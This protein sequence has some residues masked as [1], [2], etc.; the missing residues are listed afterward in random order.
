LLVCLLALAG[1]GGGDKPSS[2]P[3]R[4]AGGGVGTKDPVPNEQVEDAINRIKGAAT[5]SGCEAVKGL[6]H[7]TYGDVSDD[8][9]R[10]VKAEIGGFRD[11]RGAAYG[12][13]AAID[14]QTASGQERTAVLVLD[15]DRTFRLDF[16]L[17]TL[18]PTIGTS[19]PAAF[20]RNAA[21]VV[22]AM[23]TGDCTAFLRLVSRT[24]GLGVG[25]D[26]EVCGRVSEVPFRRELVAN[27]AARPVPLGGDA[28][29]SFYKLRTRP[30]AY[31]TM[32]MVREDPASG[33]GSPRYVLVNALPAG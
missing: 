23:Q 4:T 22:R 14:F 20:D 17:E 2:D 30:D 32:V 27:P 9:C 13:G 3:K 15:A 29:V 31:Y 7:S 6:L 24:M 18:Q 8:A 19:K 5:A 11:P 25:S 33:V 16:V 26:Q 12:T 10:A 28:W 1:C 21:A